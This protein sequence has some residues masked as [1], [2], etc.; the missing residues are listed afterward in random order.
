[1]NFSKG[2]IMLKRLPYFSG[3]NVLKTL[4]V[5]M[6]LALFSSPVFALDLDTARSTGLAGETDSG[7]LAIPPGA[8]S[9]A[10]PLIDR[11]NTQRE[12]EY[13]RISGQNNVSVE[14][15]GKLMFQKIYA[16][17][18]SGTW[19]RIQGNWSQK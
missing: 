16:T 14:D 13:Q 10:Q 3:P 5:M 7:L 11:I 6:L 19:I 17:L 18:P 1:M 4:T 9:E 12:A 2:D 8:G 15:V